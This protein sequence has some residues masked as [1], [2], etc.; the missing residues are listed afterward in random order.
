MSILQKESKNYRPYSKSHKYSNSRARATRAYV[1]YAQFYAGKMRASSA[2][3][4][5]K[6][7]SKHKPKLHPAP[8]IECAQW[9]S[10]YLFV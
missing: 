10:A 7:A 8:H 9:D 3:I 2:T 6:L 4:L 5:I 1:V